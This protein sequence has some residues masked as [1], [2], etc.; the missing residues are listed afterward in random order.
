M[1]K[2]KQAQKTWE[3]L[4]AIRL[5]LVDDI[6]PSIKN[7]RKELEDYHNELLIGNA[8]SPSIKAKISGLEG[9]L[10]ELKNQ[11][12][13]RVAQILEMH[14]NVFGDGETEDSIKSKLEAFLEDAQQLFEETEGKKEEFDS[15]YA[16]V[17]GE[18]NSDGE[19]TGGLKSELESYTAKYDNLFQRIESLLPGA[20]SAGLAKVFEDKVNEYADEARKWTKWFLV[21]V[22]IISI[23]YAIY[24]WLKPVSDSFTGSFLNLFHKTPFLVFAVWMLVFIGNR[25]AESKK[26]EES[27]KHKEV[28]A[29]AYVGYKEHVEE[30]EGESTEKTLLKKHMDNLLN[31]INEDSGKFLS[32]EGDKHPLW[33]KIFPKSEASKGTDINEN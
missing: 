11:T 9:K 13:D 10:T 31:A 12:S 28:M 15:F 1:A 5:S 27:Y 2:L 4:E 20:T 14:R 8:E 6:F 3:E 30:L 21:V 16:K 25:R 7:T 26:L 17:F 23:Y 32:H 29:R 18:E 19:I 24:L 33:D 22:S